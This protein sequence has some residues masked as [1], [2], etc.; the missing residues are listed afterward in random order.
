MVAQ[1]RNAE[2]GVR[3]LVASEVTE[4]LGR[5]SG[6]AKEA[7]A[8][9]AQ[10]VAAVAAAVIGLPAAQQK[11]LKG[12]S[13]DVASMIAAF[14]RE[15]RPATAIRIPAPAQEA[16]KGSGFGELV[17][18]DEGRRR[19]A[20]YVTE[21][22]LEDWAGPVAGSTMLH[23]QGIARSTLHDWQKRGEVIALLTG[24][25]K[26]A[27]PLEQFVD[28]RPVQGISDVLEIAGNPRRAWLWLVQQSPLLGE[29]RPIDLL[30]QDR[31]RDVADAA[32]TVFE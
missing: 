9:T 20:G 29:K 5:Q 2:A 30:K 25:R 8:N 28:G 16:S 17:D 18:L 10:I 22:S 24:A 12:K 13:A 1:V 4:V 32:R 23:E 19:L 11:R 15:E 31:C 3:R 21:G 14:A 27:F 6:L 7:V 26:H